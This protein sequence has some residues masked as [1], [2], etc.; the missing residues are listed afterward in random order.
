MDGYQ[1]CAEDLPAVQFKPSAM[2]VSQPKPRKEPSS[3]AG[4]RNAHR[5][6]KNGKP[7]PTVRVDAIIGT[8][9]LSGRRLWSSGGVPP[10]PSTAG[11]RLTTPRVLGAAGFRFAAP[12]SRSGGPSSLEN[13]LQR[14]ST[15]VTRAQ[16]AG[17]STGESWRSPF[18]QIGGRIAPPMA[19]AAIPNRPHTGHC[20]LQP[21]KGPA[22]VASVL[23]RPAAVPSEGSTAREALGYGE[24]PLYLHLVPGAA[25]GTPRSAR[26][27]RTGGHGVNLHAPVLS[28]GKP[29]RGMPHN[30]FDLPTIDLAS[31]IVTSQSPAVAQPKP[32]SWGR[33]PPGQ[34]SP[35]GVATR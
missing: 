30:Q 1:K 16:T 3:L 4:K 33:L 32:G 8:G 21:R 23:L 7:R 22:P 12:P 20:I 29:H 13:E 31:A 5:L 17:V 19:A 24:G 28:P 9:P 27:L 26:G 15:S 18:E 34:T 25:P 6:K 11:S 14:S 2:D 10:P 35:L